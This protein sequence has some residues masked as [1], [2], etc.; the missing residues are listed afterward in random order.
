MNTKHRVTHAHVNMHVDD[1]TSMFRGSFGKVGDWPHD[2]AHKKSERKCTSFFSKS[3]RGI[4]HKTDTN[5]E[6][7]EDDKDVKQTEPRYH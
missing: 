3:A 5:I 2:Q 6:L 1:D 4:K 7:K